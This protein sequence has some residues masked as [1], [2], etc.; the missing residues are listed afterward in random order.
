VSAIVDAL[1]RVHRADPH[2]PL[3]HLP[4]VGRSLDADDLWQLHVACVDGLRAAGIRPG[5]LILSAAGNRPGLVAVF[6]AC[7]AMDLVLVPV[8]AGTTMPEIA[9]LT[10]RLGA[11]AIVLPAG[12][13][14]GGET[15]AL[16]LVDGLVLRMSESAAMWG[17]PAPLAWGPHGLVAEGAAVMKLT[18]GSTAAPKATITTDAQLVADTRQI[19]EGMQIG[20]D[21][22]QICAIPLSHAYGLSVIL[23]PL[24]LQGTPVVMRDSFVPALLPSDAGAYG[25]KVF[26][27]VPFMFQHFLAHPP[28]AGWPPNVRKLISAGARLPIETARDFFAAFGLKIHSFYGTTET[29]G[30]AYDDSETMDDGDTVGPPL[31]GV[32]IALVQQEGIPNGTGRI[33]VRSAGVS[34]GYAGEQHGLFRDDGFLTGDYGALDERGRLRIA[35]RV[36]SFINV[37]GMKVEP[38]EVERVLRLMP[39]IRDACV[40]GAVDARRGEQVVA[41]VVAESGLTVFAVRQFCSARLAPH[42]I[43]RTILMVEAI[44]KT[45]RGKVDRLALDALVADRIAR[46]V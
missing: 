9:E 15:P 12:A 24:L 10:H 36:S 32:T 44:P 40:T 8:D 11:I 28:A 37:A 17:A 20:P 29:G 5:H 4:G 33:F 38:E 21:D 31:P 26:P 7:R 27:G 6:V 13:A 35:G 43:P 25:A 14:G 3:I 19:I 18:S 1:A 42:K 46:P 45:A 30:I 39:G 22:T 34:S 2:R 23:M 16:P 41:C